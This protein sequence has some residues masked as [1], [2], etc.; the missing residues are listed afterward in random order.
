MIAGADIVEVTKQLNSM[1]Q[2]FTPQPASALS[3]DPEMSVSML[4][5]QHVAEKQE[6]EADLAEVRQE[7]TSELAE[8]NAE[9]EHLKRNLTGA[10][11]D[12]DTT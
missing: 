8:A 11:R 4:S 2:Q 9:L 7:L 10:A 12:K 5:A 6:L 1:Y 3:E